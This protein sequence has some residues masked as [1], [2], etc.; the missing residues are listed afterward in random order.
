M[1]RPRSYIVCI[2]RQGF[3]ALS[4][5]LEDTHTSA[6]HAF[7]NPEELL[8]LLCPSAVDVEPAEHKGKHVTT[9]QA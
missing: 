6:I 3:R 7:R 2:H 8:A 1:C 9:C 4:G 5:L